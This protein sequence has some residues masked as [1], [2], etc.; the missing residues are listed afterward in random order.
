MASAVTD[1]TI[2][3]IEGVAEGYEAYFGEK[4]HGRHH[5]YP[6]PTLTQ[7][8][9]Q[10]NTAADFFQERG[11][12]GYIFGALPFVV[13]QFTSTLFNMPAFT[14][15]FLIS[16]RQETIRENHFVLQGSMSNLAHQFE[17]IPGMVSDPELDALVGYEIENYDA[18]FSKEG[19]I[20]HLIYKLLKAGLHRELFEI[21]THT[22]PQNS[23]ELVTS[24]LRNLPPAQLA[25]LLPALKS[26]FTEPGRRAVREYVRAAV[27]W[28]RAE[29]TTP[30]YQAAKSELSRQLSRIS[31]PSSLPAPREL[32]IEFQ[33]PSRVRSKLYG[34]MDRINIYT[35]TPDRLLSFITATQKPELRKNSH[36]EQLLKILM[37]TRIR[38][39]GDRA[40]L[41]RSLRDQI[42]FQD[43]QK[44]QMLS[45]LI[46]GIN[47]GAECFQKRCLS[48]Q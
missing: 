8:L 39:S 10:S 42:S 45:A 47:Q 48:L 9:L 15:E 23:Y 20:A 1:P 18:L 34:K 44:A 5:I 25:P 35:A 4:L 36:R 13:K 21:L 26:T 32:W 16:E 24:I 6:T 37:N 28:R 12:Q 7:M 41:T 2:A 11:Y 31:M 29:I 27:R 38:G 17:L 19:V 22:K 14:S 43:A 40:T 33:T 3:L 46:S 30:A